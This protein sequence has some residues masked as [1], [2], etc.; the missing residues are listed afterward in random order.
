MFKLR[1][2]FEQVTDE[3]TKEVL[4]SGF[5]KVAR[6]SHLV[7]DQIYDNLERFLET[8]DVKKFER[9]LGKPKKYLGAGVFGAVW[10][11]GGG[12]V[13]KIT[14][15]YREAPFLYKLSKKSK[16]GMVDVDRVVRFPFGESQAFGIIRDE[17]KPITQTKY[18]TA[19][20]D[21][22]YDMRHGDRDQLYQDPVKEKIQAALDSMYKMDPNWSGTHLENMGIQNGKFVLYDGFSKNVKY[23]PSKVPEID[24][25]KNYG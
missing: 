15:D 5:N 11:I 20:H 6:R 3:S 22:F 2:I 13:L 4:S 10:D 12:K 7:S 19:A 23:D 21:V 14:F 1:D 16:K 24:I 25:K 8:L 18:S 9:E 17:L